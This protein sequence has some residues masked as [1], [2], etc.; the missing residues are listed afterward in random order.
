M[1]GSPVSVARWS[2]ASAFS[3]DLS[4]PF[5][6]SPGHRRIEI[7]EVHVAIRSGSEKGGRWNAVSDYGHLSPRLACLGP[8]GLRQ[9]S[10]YPERIRRG[11]IAPEFAGR[12][13][14]WSV[15]PACAGWPIRAATEFR[16]QGVWV[17]VKATC[18]RRGRTFAGSLQI[19]MRF[20]LKTGLRRAELQLL[21]DAAR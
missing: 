17:A 21:T 20:P 15:L 3:Q 9:L 19:R 6:L 1:F 4:A 13:R 12:C 14:A 18:C 10:R 11:H 8:Q 2:G 7:Q 16:G 5:V